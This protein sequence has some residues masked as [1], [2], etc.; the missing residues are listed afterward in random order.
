LTNAMTSDGV[1]N[2]IDIHFIKNIVSDNSYNFVS[3]H[4]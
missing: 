4:A 1:E 3:I 2:L